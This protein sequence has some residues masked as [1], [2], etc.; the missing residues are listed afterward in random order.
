M[1]VAVAYEEFQ[2]SAV[3]V[4]TEWK[5]LTSGAAEVEVAV[6]KNTQELKQRLEVVMI[7][8]ETE[9]AFGDSHVP[10]VAVAS[11]G[12]VKTW[13]ETEYLVQER[14]QMRQASQLGSGVAFLQEDSEMHLFG[15]AYPLD[16]M[17]SQQPAYLMVELAVRVVE[18]AE[19]LVAG[20]LESKHKLNLAFT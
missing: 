3:A 14:Q 8:E 15:P 12:D 19:I 7:V 5:Q 18:D 10:Q 11:A 9:R 6:K 17:M 16:L 20:W 4:A 13:A 2:L 1:V